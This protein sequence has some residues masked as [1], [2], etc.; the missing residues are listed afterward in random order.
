MLFSSRPVFGLENAVFRVDVVR[1][2]LKILLIPALVISATAC[3]KGEDP[4]LATSSD[5][6]KTDADKD[7]PPKPMPA[8]LP[9]VLARVNGQDV[10]KVDFE[11]LLRN[12][13]M[14][15]GPVPAERRDEILR[16]ALDRLITYTVLQQEAKARN[17]TVPDAEVD[18][19]LKS[20]QGQFKDAEDFEKTLETRGMS[21]DRLRADARLDMVITRMLDAEVATAEPATDEEVKA[22]YEKNPEKFKQEEAL[23]ASHILVMV[24]EKADDAT[25]KKARAQIDGILKRARAGEDFAELAKAH[26]QD[27]SAAQGGDLDF[28][29]RG[30]MVPAFDKAAFALE[31]GE[32]SDVVTTEFGYH[33]I[34]A[35]DRRAAQTVPLETVSPQVKQ[36]LTNQKKQERADAFVAGLKQKSRIEVLI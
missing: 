6:A 2:L 16:G 27:G 23:R 28:F 5:T 7:Q 11:M 31:T 21:L 30:R 24:D 32:I 36:Y 18:K 17:I 15:Q 14:S 22:F 9:D 1:T 4:S 35:T 34:K 33:I 10:K 3:N 19:Q 26:S 20:M 29:A 12:M 8:Q 25:R 13:E